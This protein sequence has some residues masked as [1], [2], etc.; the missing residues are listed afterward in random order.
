MLLQV[1][2]LHQTNMDFGIKSEPIDHQSNDHLGSGD[3]LAG[4]ASNSLGSTT[5]STNS[6]SGTTSGGSPNGGGSSKKKKNIPVEL[7]AFGTTP[8]GKPRLFVCQVCTRAFARLEHLRR[9]E[10]S[11]TKEK[12]FCC[13]VCQR[14]FSRRDLLLRHAQKLHAG[15]AD[16]ITRLRRK[17][18]KRSGSQSHD[19]DMDG[20]DMDMEDDMDEGRTPEDM[21][22]PNGGR[23]ATSGPMD[24][25]QFNLNLFNQKK[26]QQ[27]GGVPPSTPNS[28]STRSGSIKDGTAS[29]Q[30]QMFDRKKLVKNRGASFSAQSGANYSIGLSEFN[31]LYP[32]AD[33]VEF[34]TPQMLPSSNH[35]ESWLNNL[36]TI[37]G[38]TGDSTSNSTPMQASHPNRNDKHNSI[39][40]LSLGDELPPNVSHHGSF[41]VPLSGNHDRSDSLSSVHSFPNFDMMGMYMGPDKLLQNKMQQQLQQQQQQPLTQSVP[42]SQQHPQNQKHEVPNSNPLRSN[43]GS[44]LPE[45]TSGGD[46]GYSF[47]D[48]PESMLGAAKF[49]N[50]RLPMGLSTIKQ[51][52]EEEMLEQSGN[53]NNTQQLL[54]QNQFQNLFPGSQGQHTNGNS[55]NNTN[56]RKGYHSNPNLDLNF[57]NDIGELTH[58]YDVNSK[59]MPN[60]YSFYGDNTSVSSSGVETSSPQNSST[61]QGGQYFGNGAPENCLNQNQLLNIEGAK[62][63]S[64]LSQPNQKKRTSHFKPGNYNKNK[65]FTNNMR[66][67]INRALGKYPISGIMTPSIPSN[68]KLEFY[69]NNFVNIFLSHF[70]FIHLLKL[71]EYEVMNMTAN[72]E[73]TNESARVCLPL[74]IATIGALLTNNKNDSEHLY[75]ASRRTIHIYLESRKNSV[76]DT[77]PQQP[78]SQQQHTSPGLSVDEFANTINGH[79]NN[80]GV[81]TNDDKKIP[82]SVN[83]LWLIQSLTLSVIY[84]LFSD[85]EN[86]VYIVIRQ[87]NALNSLVKTSVKSNRTVLFSIYGEDYENYLK[88]SG[89]ATDSVTGGSPSKSLF[90]YDV[91][92]EIKFKNNI[93]IQSQKRIVFMIYRLTNFLLMMY[94]VPLTLSIN[95]LGA[96]DA[97][98]KCDEYLWNFRSF[99]HFQEYKQQNNS[100]SIGEL[101]VESSKNKI[102]FRD[103]L[104]LITKNFNT[105][106]PAPHLPLF[107][108]LQNLSLFGFISI[109]HGIFEIK[110]YQEMR[111]VDVFMLLD[112]LTKFVGKEKAKYECLNKV[113]EDFEK[114]DYALLASFTKVS[115]LVNI[116][117]VKEQSWLRN[118]DELSKNFNNLLMNM[119]NISDYDYLR[120]VDCCMIILKLILFR[121]EDAEEGQQSGGMAGFNN[122]L[123]RS[124]SFHN[125]INE[126][127]LGMSGAGEG[128][129]KGHLGNTS[130]EF[131]KLMN[132]KVFFEF[133]NLKASIHSQMLFHIFTI[134]S[135]FST[136]MIRRMH[137]KNSGN[138]IIN[139]FQGQINEFDKELT[140]R[141]DFIL[142]VLGKIESFLKDKYEN[143]KLDSDF[144]SLYLYSQNGVFTNTN[145]SL[146]KS[147]YILKIGE[148][149]LGYMYD[150]N[151]KVCIF[152]KLSGSLS[153]LRKFM[154]DN[155]AR[156]LN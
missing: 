60:G 150:T 125:L 110:Q 27:V 8:S 122:D 23:K 21:K 28:K 118:Y 153:Q 4:G 69:L 89:E 83:P 31:E 145:Y 91:H 38:M 113:Q 41:S 142:R 104:L 66:Y 109:I 33:T 81:P 106:Q 136:F 64:P 12:P 53:Y 148:L 39:T 84:G 46:Y 63:M 62:A 117:L 37:P 17:S 119:N 154:I 121:T 87:L 25:V 44:L 16:A 67:M 129:G 95:D 105:G 138:H 50:F 143:L 55:N 1:Q 30:R 52:E 61:P 152:Q 101:L 73:L 134:F 132:L 6:E 57:L 141:F 155:E 133:D 128:F 76:D 75:E 3:H 18:M 126:S 107:E 15:C 71:N 68:E 19:L 99:Q 74:L 10:R 103:A 100:I 94:N 35:D 13:G 131:E 45:H 130:S 97:P 22:S 48:I 146:E 11:H 78:G 98:N 70:P 32:G 36:S 72:E 120:I 58:E 42:Q 139:E 47:Y 86:N 79:K 56:N 144:A 90:S 7:T 102:I 49:E 93:N 51:E 112:N 5:T 34:S 111:N 116:K 115:S 147:L 151:I 9:H 149:V 140:Q 127:L 135:L 40:S 108:K 54:Q 85:N 123:V 88:C 114:L 20:M 2:Q 124:N 156:I 137:F 14:K 80:N 24:S 92:D 59:F 26:Y 29:L 96:L 65:L 82:Q 77:A 43:M